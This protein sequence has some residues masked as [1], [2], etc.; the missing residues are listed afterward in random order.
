MKALPRRQNKRLQ[1][2]F[3]IQSLPWKKKTQQINTKLTQQTNLCLHLAVEGLPRPS[4]VVT[5]GFM[6]V[7]MLKGLQLCP[8]AVKVLTF[9]MIAYT[10]VSNI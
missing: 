5:P 10:N 3:T 2:K 1:S 7:L 9:F 4:T 6:R 8:S